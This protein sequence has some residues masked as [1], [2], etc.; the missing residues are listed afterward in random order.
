M[1]CSAEQKNQI[2]DVLLTHAH[3]DHVAGLPLFI[4]D[5]FADLTEP[6]RIFATDEVIEVLEQ[7]IFNW[8]VYPRFS[9]LSNARGA[10]MEYYAF[11]VGKEFTVK[12]IRVKAVEV[13]HHVP[14]VGF[15]L[16]DGETT[17]A[18]SSDTAEMKD[19]WRET[20]AA[21][22]LKAILI[23]CAFPNELRDLADVSYHLTPKMLREEIKKSSQKNCPIYLINLKPMYRE[24]IIREIREMEIENL[25]IMD[26]GKIYDW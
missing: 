3:L 9:E 23:E 19:F 11:E 15:V 16:S 13:N 4:D 18:I 24:K 17:L 6:V 20:N 26:V 21:E 1:G 10:V 25:F 22:N 7:H 8:S 12:N 2:R 14:A 5:L